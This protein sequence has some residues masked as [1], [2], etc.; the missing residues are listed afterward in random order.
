MLIVYAYLSY[1]F[2]KDF[3]VILHKPLIYIWNFYRKI[4]ICL[5]QD[6]FTKRKKEVF[7]TSYP[8][9]M[10]STDFLFIHLKS[11]I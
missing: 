4:M 7:Y 9:I 1:N 10:P 11:K 5:R 2:I 6:V 3:I 8:L